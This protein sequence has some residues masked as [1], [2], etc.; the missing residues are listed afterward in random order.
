M[1]RLFATHRLLFRQVPPSTDLI[2]R[3]ERRCYIGG[4]TSIKIGER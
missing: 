4:E 2:C 3:V 1:R